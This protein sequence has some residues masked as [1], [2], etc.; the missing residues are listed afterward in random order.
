MVRYALAMTLGSRCSASFLGLGVNNCERH[1]VHD[2]PL[3]SV[4][5]S[6]VED[7]KTPLAIDFSFLQRSSDSFSAED[8]MCQNGWLPNLKV[9]LPLLVWHFQ[10]VKVRLFIYS[11]E[12]KRAVLCPNT[13]RACTPPV[14]RR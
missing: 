5:R 14:I 8:G 10:A 12:L 9:L 2:W 11:L 6:I 4:A 1:S 7:M 3:V 13:N